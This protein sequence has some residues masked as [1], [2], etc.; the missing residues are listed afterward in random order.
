MN[1]PE[2]PPTGGFFVPKIT[3]SRYMENATSKSK[4]APRAFYSGALYKGQ[5][6]TSLI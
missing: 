6:S 1:I 4:N 2:M 3:V 5:Y